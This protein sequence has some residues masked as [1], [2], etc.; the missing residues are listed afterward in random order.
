MPSVA[1]FNVAPVKSAQLHHPEE[2]D[3]T[4]HGAAGDRRF[5]FLD[6]E[7]HR[8]SGEAKAG[9]L[10]IGAR[11]SADTDHLSLTFP[12]GSEVG[13]PASASGPPFPVALYD[14]QVKVRTV[15]GP[16]GEAVSAHIGRKVRLAR[17]QDGERAGGLPPV[18]LVSLASVADLAT[19]GGVARLDPRRFRMLIELDGCDP[20]EED[21]WAGR[22]LRVGR[23]ELRVTGPTHRCTLTN[24]DPDTGERDFPTLELL[25]AYRRSETGLGFGRYAEVRRAGSVRVGDEVEVLAP[26]ATG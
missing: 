9:L 7:G 20:Y 24:L 8:F 6:P 23:A 18:S 11:Y 14:H 5:L 2:I 19:R 25:A 1:R 22:V 3:L 21:A 13:G 4:L 16:F 15:E 26:G 12:D 10:G 17:M